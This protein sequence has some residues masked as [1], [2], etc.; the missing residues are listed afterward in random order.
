MK[1]FI[2]ITL[3]LLMITCSCCLLTSCSNNYT[4]TLISEHNQDFT[5]TKCSGCNGDPILQLIHKGEHFDGVLETRKIKKGSIV[6]NVDIDIK[7]AEKKGYRFCGWYTDESWTI[8]WNTML[9]QVNGNVTLYA[10]WEKI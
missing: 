8:Q 10:K 3:M 5:R 7:L 1:K 9:D 2:A 4:V 6:G